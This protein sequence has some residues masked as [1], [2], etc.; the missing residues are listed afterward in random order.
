VQS[1]VLGVAICISAFVGDLFESLL[2]R[3]AQAKDSGKLLLG[4]GGVLDRFDAL[5]F[6]TVAAYL[7]TTAM[8]Y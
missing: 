7:V 1:L 2:K 3:D 5:L 4:H 8:V 6:S